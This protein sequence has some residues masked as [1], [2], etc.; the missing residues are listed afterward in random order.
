MTGTH[1][2][3]ISP[4]ISITNVTI[5]GPTPININTPTVFTATV[6]PVSATQ[7]ITYVWE[8]TDLPP[9][10]HTGG[11]IDLPTFTWSAPGTKTLTV[12]ASNRYAFAVSEI[13]VDVK[14]TYRLYLP[15]V[16]KNAP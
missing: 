16:L 6:S 9:I 7:P 12:T 10:T 11:T 2:I 3:T 14:Q 8:A 4:F 5:N 13:L 15:I 1:A